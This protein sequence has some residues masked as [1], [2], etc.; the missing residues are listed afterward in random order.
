MEKAMIDQREVSTTRMVE[1]KGENQIR[2]RVEMK[3]DLDCAKSILKKQG[4][5]Q[6]HSVNTHTHLGLGNV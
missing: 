2:E 3:K 5:K 1:E 4:A 6:D